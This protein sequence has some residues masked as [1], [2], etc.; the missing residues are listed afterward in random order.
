[1]AAE[2]PT[3]GGVV[4]WAE[5]LAQVHDDIAPRFALAE[6]RRR[7]LAYP[8]GLL[9][10]LERKNGWHLAEEAGERR[11]DGTQRLLSTAE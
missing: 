6:P 10:P 7:A 11:P 5:E 8:R 1:M 9:S 3:I 2:G 4:E